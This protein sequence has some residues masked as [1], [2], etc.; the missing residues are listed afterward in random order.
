M[1]QLELGQ[2]RGFSLFNDAIKLE[3]HTEFSSAQFPSL[4]CL[5]FF[6]MYLFI[7]RGG[8]GAEGENLKQTPC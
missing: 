7:F 2:E 5:Y 8:G 3:L 1:V 4:F 6:K